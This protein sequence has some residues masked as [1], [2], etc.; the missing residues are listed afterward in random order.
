MLTLAFILSHRE[1]RRRLIGALPD[2]PV[3]PSAEPVEQR[4]GEPLDRPR[5]AQRR[6]H[7]AFVAPEP[8]RC[9]EE[10]A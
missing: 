2:D 10:V 7:M 6:A 4:S 1:L 5:P 3:L 8:A 9:D